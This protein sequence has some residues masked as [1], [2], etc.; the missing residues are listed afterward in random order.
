MVPTGSTPGALDKG[1]VAVPG[2][3]RHDAAA[4]LQAE[5]AKVKLAV[6]HS[7]LGIPKHQQPPSS[8]GVT[9][10]QSPADQLLPRQEAGSG[11]ASRTSWNPCNHSVF[12]GL[13]LGALL[14]PVY[15]VMVTTE[16]CI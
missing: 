10:S 8:R 1:P 15:I 12:H 6:R 9:R 16:P 11:A 3:V 4:G 2:W 14:E 13:I 7:S 5:F